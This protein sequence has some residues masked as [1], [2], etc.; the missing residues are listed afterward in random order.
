MVPVNGI[1]TGTGS[2]SGSQAGNGTSARTEAVHWAVCWFVDGG[3]FGSAAGAESTSGFVRAG[4]AA[5]RKDHI[6][7]P[8]STG[9]TGLP[10]GE[11]GRTAGGSAGEEGWRKEAKTGGEEK[12][13][14]RQNCEC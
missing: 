14:P 3:G 7:Q 2:M 11:G 12:G 8:P 5:E 1:G 6:P 10:L 4:D 13:E 9:W